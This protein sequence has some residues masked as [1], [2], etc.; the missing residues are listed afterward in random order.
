[1]RCEAVEVYFEDAIQGPQRRQMDTDIGDFVI[2]RKDH[3]P[4]YQLATAYDDVAQNISHVVRGCDLI[5]STPRQIYLQK[6]LGKTSPQYAHLPVLAKADGQ[7][8]S[9]QNLAAPLNPDTSNSNLLKALTLLNQAPP[10]SLVGASCADI[11]DWAIS[12][13]QLNR[14][15]RT[16]A[17][18]KTQPDF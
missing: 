4:A 9:K 12:N 2:Y 15:P 8:L 6:L 1:M 7:K 16:S 18:R 10:K 5:D 13:W 11:I 3:L 17:I 14:V